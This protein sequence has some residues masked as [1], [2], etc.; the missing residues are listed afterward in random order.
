MLAAISRLIIT[1]TLTGILVN[2]H[3]RPLNACSS[4]GIWKASVFLILGGILMRC[5]LLPV[6]ACLAVAA[7]AHAGLMG[8]T[9]AQS[10][11][12]P[13]AATPYPSATPLPAVFTV[14]A[15][16]EGVVDVEGVT[17]LHVDFADHGLTVDFDTL[18]AQ[19][20]W[21]AV[22]FNGLAFESAAFA[23]IDRVALTDATLFPGFDLSRVTHD[24]TTLRLNFAGLT[25]D[26]STRIGLAFGT[27]PEPATWA[28]MI[29]GFGMAGIAARRRGRPARPMRLV[30]LS[31]PR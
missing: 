7:P 30:P 6:A 16:V 27:V 26:D 4:S 29:T 10:Y 15:G 23:A 8:A 5:F 31:L 18:L 25:Y 24:N 19:P 22:A 21:N 14:G 20:T 12:Y 13:D 9:V 1:D 2:E 11:R 28:L 17:F 3:S